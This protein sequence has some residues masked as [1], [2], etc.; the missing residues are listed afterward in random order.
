MNERSSSGWGS[1]KVKSVL[2]MA[3]V[4]DVVATSSTGYRRYLFRKAQIIIKDEAR[5]LAEGVGVMGV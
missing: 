1:F 5:F 4:M 3:E 2:E